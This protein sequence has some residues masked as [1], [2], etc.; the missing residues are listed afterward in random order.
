MSLALYAVVAALGLPMLILWV[1]A[2]RDRRNAGFASKAQL[3]R[4]LSA[5][6]VVQA[7]DIRPSL[8]DDG[9]PRSPGVD[10]DKR[11]PRSRTS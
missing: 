3:R 2:R 5:K 9:R 8:M 10:L 11:S 4:H 6:A 1:A 7:T